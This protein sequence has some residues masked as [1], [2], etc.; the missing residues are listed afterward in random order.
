VSHS[1]PFLPTQ[2]SLQMFIAMSYW[3][4][5]R[6]LASAT[7][8]ILDPHGDFSQISCSVSWR[9]CGFGSAVPATPGALVVLILVDVGVGLGSS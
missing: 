4:G 1:K 5:L 9:S 6:L 7:L 3:S 2:L 8:S